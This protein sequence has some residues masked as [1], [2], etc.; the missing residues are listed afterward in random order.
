MLSIGRGLASQ[1][2]FIMLDEPSG[3]APK[4]VDDIYNKLSILKEKGLTVL[5]IRTK[6]KLCP[7]PRRKSLCIRKWQDCHGWR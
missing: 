6:Y 1:P 2:K 5:L 4:L 3:I 7:A